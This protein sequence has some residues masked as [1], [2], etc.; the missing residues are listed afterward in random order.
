MLESLEGRSMLATFTV[1]TTND[2]GA[3]SIRDAIILANS[4]TGTDTIAF[5]IPG[6]GVQTIMPLS[7]LPAIT[8][9]VVVDGTTQGISSSPLIEIDGTSAG[10]TASGIRLAAG[11]NTLRGLA[12]TNFKLNGILITSNG[13]K[14]EG[15]YIGLDP[16]G[17][18]AAPNLLD[19]IQISS[20]F[21]TIGGATIDTANFISGNGRNGVFIN[22]TAATGNVLV[23]NT[24]GLNST[25]TSKVANVYAGVRIAGGATFNN[26]GSLI[27]AE[28]NFI[29]GNIAFG[30]LIEGLGTDTNIVQGNA[31]GNGT[32]ASSGLG[33]G[34]GVAVRSGA[35]SNSIGT[36]NANGGNTI[37]GNV[38]WGVQLRGTGTSL[39]QVVGNNI[40]G[41]NGRLARLA[42]G[43]DGI[44]I[45]TRASNNTIGG[46]T[47]AHT[48]T[49]SGN[50]KSGINISGSGTDA[51][52]VLNNL[53]GLN[54]TGTTAVPNL[55][56]GITIRAGATNNQIGSAGAGNTISGNRNVGIRVQGTSGNFI[57]SNVIGLSI[58][59][60]NPVANSLDG[61]VLEQG[62]TNNIVGGMS[63]NDTNVVSGNIRAGVRISGAGTTGNSVLLNKIGTAAD[64]TIARGNLIGVWITSGAKSNSVGAANAG[65]TLSGNLMFG[66]SISGVNTENNIVR[67]N[68]IGLTEAGSAAQPNLDGV[69]ISAGAKNNTIGGNAAVDRNT[70][71]GNSRD[72]I[73]LTG[74]ATS[75]NTIV[76]NSIGVAESA[77]AVS[78]ARYGV[79]IQL[80][81][82]SAI[83]SPVAPRNIISNN[84]AA[85]IY[86]SD[87]GSSAT[88]VNNIVGLLPDGSLTGLARQGIVVMNDATAV[89]G[90]AGIN[91]GNVISGNTDGIV[92]SRAAGANIQG[93][94]IG[95]DPSGTSARGNQFGVRIIVG[96][97]VTMGSA[98]AARNV[99]AG[100]SLSAIIASL[101]ANLTFKGNYIGTDRTG[102]LSIPNGRGMEID[103]CENIQIGGPL[104][105]DRN[106]MSGNSF[107]GLSLG[108]I[109]DASDVADIRV[110]NNYI[111]IGSD[112][113]TALPNNVGVQVFGGRPGLLFGNVISAN[114]GNGIEGSMRN[115][116][117]FGNKIGVLADGITPAGNGQRGIVI[118]N[119]G[120]QNFIGGE[121]DSDAN[122]IGYNGNDGILI[123]SDPAMGMSVL[124]GPG[125]TL[126]R[127]FFYSNGGQSIDL[128]S[129]SGVSI[130][131]VDDVDG[132]ANNLQNYPVVSVAT[133]V[134]G[135]LVLRGILDSVQARFRIDFYTGPAAGLAQKH[136]GFIFDR[137]TTNTDLQFAF[138]LEADAEVGDF[139]MAI[140]TNL[141]TGDSSELSVAVQVV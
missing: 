66:V 36:A 29:S 27:S 141:E 38:T 125:N 68:L 118:T 123:G 112:G 77:P 108:N 119:G 13:N 65:N 69:N 139:L 111:G 50:A 132:G 89:I 60:T 120:T 74:A 8:D 61:I 137:I 45:D 52:R 105:A 92:V 12:V 94:L 3:G 84:G 58:D 35:K 2:S 18:T 57:R 81:A 99:V 44:L 128:G 82:K 73:S 78:N 43:E 20:S 11:A 103:R 22:G 136:V 59:R 88:I 95:L 93:N 42:N 110:E 55:M 86:V 85:G 24:I 9:S 138:I 46:A 31:I 129:N 54:S 14:I 26:V 21:N 121:T 41:T 51:N 87:A 62:A 131:D 17:L 130:N 6:A 1:V 49:I 134:D 104:S 5:A 67:S 100:N 114:S 71:T 75:G 23:R 72:G 28:K 116:R 40:G 124:A 37:S 56:A 16:D 91:D 107:Y 135:S 101:S 126:L 113:T 140:A 63:A 47:A 98:G 127:N 7:P 102:L 133:V 64:T 115:Q 30:V 25:R 76:G 34:V 19:G 33:N 90:G 117:I 4:T 122:I 80:G 106:V 109:G 70:I 96:Q 15:S 97:N 48:N 10:T 83:G 53:I 32:V 79:S 39:N